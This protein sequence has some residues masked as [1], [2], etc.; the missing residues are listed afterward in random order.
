VKPERTAGLAVLALL[1]AA[2]L[3]NLVFVA[4]SG[5][6]LRPRRAGD[7]APDFTAAR[8]NGEG[9]QTA[10]HDLRGQVVLI[11]FW[12]TW[13]GPCRQSMPTMERLYQKYGARGFTIMSMNTE[14][15]RQVEAARRFAAGFQPA[16]TFPIYLDPGHVVRDYEVDVLPTMVLLD[17]QGL[18]RWVHIGYS[19]AAGRELEERVQKLL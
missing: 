15:P 11:D 17:R 10:L 16:L 8:L 1:S 9:G 12:A 19:E 3:W 6:A 7:L 2:L 14:G 5:S 18:V 4:R 13:C